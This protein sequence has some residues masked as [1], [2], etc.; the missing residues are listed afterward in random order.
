MSA[1]NDK[2]KYAKNIANEMKKVASRVE[3]KIVYILEV[4]RNSNQP[5]RAI[6]QRTKV[7]SCS[8]PRELSRTVGGIFLG[9]YEQAGTPGTTGCS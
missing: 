8:L 5:T 7:F 2:T 3:S 4:L 1:K 9:C 6:L